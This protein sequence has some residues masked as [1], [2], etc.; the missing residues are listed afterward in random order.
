MQPKRK[1]SIQQR[2]KHGHLMMTL[3][4]AAIQTWFLLHDS[5]QIQHTFWLTFFGRY[6]STATINMTYV[7]QKNAGIHFPYAK[8][9]LKSLYRTFKCWRSADNDLV[10]QYSIDPV[11]CDFEGYSLFGIANTATLCSKTDGAAWDFCSTMWGL[12]CSRNTPHCKKYLFFY[13]GFCIV[14][15]CAHIL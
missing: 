6:A 12:D 14:S 15:K 10:L 4:L 8:S 11:T 3:L 9:A 13:K 1:Q 2:L 7:L 5:M